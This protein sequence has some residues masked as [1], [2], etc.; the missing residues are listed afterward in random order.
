MKTLIPAGDSNL[1][2]RLFKAL[3][4]PIRRLRGVLLDALFGSSINVKPQWVFVD[5]GFTMT[6]HYHIRL[7]SEVG[8]KL[9]GGI[10]TPTLCGI[11][12]RLY[13]DRELPLTDAFLQDACK[14]CVSKYREVG[15]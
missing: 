4:S 12:N 8:L 3:I 7:L 6:G 15:S 9:G 2:Q 14:A 1:P 11:T 5:N 13:S 10:D